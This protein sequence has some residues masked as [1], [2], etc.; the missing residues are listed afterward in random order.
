LIESLF[1]SLQ[2]TFPAAN[3]MHPS[4]NR[5]SPLLGIYRS[6]EKLNVASLSRPTVLFQ[7]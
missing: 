5:L 2:L 6:T 7:R 3:D 4:G 1:H